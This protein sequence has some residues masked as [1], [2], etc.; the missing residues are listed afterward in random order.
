MRVL[1]EEAERVARDGH[2]AFVQGEP[3]CGKDLVARAIH[4]YSSRM[5]QPWTHFHCGAVPLE[6]IE[7]QVFELFAEAGRGTLFLEEVQLLPFGLQAQLLRIID[8]ESVQRADC[9]TRYSFGFRLVA[10]SLAPLQILDQDRRLVPD[11]YRCFARCRLSVPPLRERPIDILPLAEFY[12]EQWAGGGR[13]R[14]LTQDALHALESYDWPGNVEELQNV[15]W[16]AVANAS[17]EAVTTLDLP[18]RVLDSYAAADAGESEIKRLF[19]TVTESLDSSEREVTGVHDG[20]MLLLMERRLL[21][22][23]VAR[24][25]GHSARAAKMLGISTHLLNERCQITLGRTGDGTN[26]TE[27]PCAG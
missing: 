12:L 25:G 27:L 3:G 5:L 9:E 22:M 15:L 16:A 2:T 18:E 4:H 10:S 20:A 6:L 11:L 7:K 14:H 26:R 13:S 23:V 8:G 24:S 17:A 19:Q 1:F 21:E